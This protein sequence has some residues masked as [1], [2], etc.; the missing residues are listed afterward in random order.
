[1]SARFRHMHAFT[2]ALIL[3]AAEIAG[4]VFGDLFRSP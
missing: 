4:V 2:S 1:M 3:G